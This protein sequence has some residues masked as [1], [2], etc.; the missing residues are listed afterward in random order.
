MWYIVGAVED[1]REAF[2]L[3][4]ARGQR[5]HGREEQHQDLRPAVWL[6]GDRPLSVAPSKLFFK[7]EK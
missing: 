7:I 5:G 2:P 6:R 3:R 4:Q 1:H